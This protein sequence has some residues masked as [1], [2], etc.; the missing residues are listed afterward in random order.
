MKGRLRGHAHLCGDWVGE[1][2]LVGDHA[3]DWRPRELT[4]LL[5][6]V[7]SRLG[8]ATVPPLEPGDVLVAGR[9]FGVETRT[10]WPALLLSLAGFGAVIAES[11]LPSFRDAC[12]HAGLPVLVLPGARLTTGDGHDLI[13]NLENGTVENVTTHRVLLASPM[14]PTELRLC[15]DAPARRLLGAWEAPRDPDVI[16]ETTPPPGTSV[17]GLP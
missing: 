15:R 9:G 2:K 13:L 17:P 1:R 14:S 3:A 7:P 8:L 16:E 4:R 6:N 11:V 10:D 5:A 12:I